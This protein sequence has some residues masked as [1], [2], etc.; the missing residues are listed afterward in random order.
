MRASPLLGGPL[1]VSVA[2]ETP[3]TAAK[4]GS[5]ATALGTVTVKGVIKRQSAVTKERVAT[6]VIDSVSAEEIAAAGDSN[7]GEAIRRVT[8]VSVQNNVVVVR[9]LGDRYSTTLVNGAEIPSFNPSRRVVSVDAFPSEFLGGLT[10]Q[11]TYSAD[12]PGEFSGGVALIETRPTPDFEAGSIKLNVG[13]NTQTTLSPVL[14]YQG[15]DFD[16]LG[17]DG[18]QRDLPG[19]YRDVTNNGANTLGGAT[20]AD[21]RALLQSLPNLFDLQRIDKAPADFGGS[22]SYGNVYKLKARRKSASRS[23]VCTTPTTASVAKIAACS[24][25]AVA[26]VR[27]CR[28]RTSRNCSA[29]SRPSKP[30][31]PWASA[32]N[33]RS[34]TRSTSS[35]CC[36]ARLRKARSSAAQWPATPA[37][38]PIRSA[39]RSITSKAS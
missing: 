12:L 33:T 39:S 16:Y 18:G 26:A 7:A 11:K 14:T 8:G 3:A 9:G 32:T 38:R 28:V 24:R 31:A 25:P 35:P 10:V 36:R 6:S 29:P 21:R 17:F 19:A 1:A 23:P 27:T 30:A 15:S 22:L 37:S 13:G 34:S 5:G 2:A 4:P 20:L